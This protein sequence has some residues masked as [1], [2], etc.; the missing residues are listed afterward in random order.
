MT[1]EEI[2]VYKMRITQAGVGELTVIM[3]EMEMQWLKEALDA[4]EKGDMETYNGNL[5]KAS[6][7][8]VELMN[9]LNLEGRICGIHI[10]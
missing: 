10:L 4:Y 1:T 3:L 2:N 8:Q 9:V 5:D 7:T 6:A